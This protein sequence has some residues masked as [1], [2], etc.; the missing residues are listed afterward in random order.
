LH[1]NLLS[2]KDNSIRFSDQPLSAR[3][4]H[5][6][7]SVFQT[8]KEGTRYFKDIAPIGWNA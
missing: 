7:F 6:P 4:I 2:S 5:E 1:Q 8:V 3:I